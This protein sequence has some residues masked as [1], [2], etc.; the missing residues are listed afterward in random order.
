MEDIYRGWRN[1]F[2]SLTEAVARK[3]QEGRC[4][5]MPQTENMT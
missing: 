4:H 1:K 5:R 3:I 2:Y